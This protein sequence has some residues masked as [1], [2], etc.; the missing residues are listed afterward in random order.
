MTRT[1][2]TKWRRQVIT[3]H[4]R[5]GRCWLLIHSWTVPTGPG[6]TE[7]TRSHRSRKRRKSVQKFSVRVKNKCLVWL[8]LLVP[9]DVP[10]GEEA[11]DHS[12]LG[13]WE[14]HELAVGAEAVVRLVSQ[15]R[16]VGS[17]ALRYQYEVW[18][19]SIQKI[20]STW[21]QAGMSMVPR[22][23]SLGSNIL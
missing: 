8:H 15:S 9:E 3:W 18:G 22:G 2:F 1:Q 21:A 12:V 16:T 20:M 4:S 6:T 7:G 23:K 17:R 19:V 11:G 5:L 13:V 14:L 10:G